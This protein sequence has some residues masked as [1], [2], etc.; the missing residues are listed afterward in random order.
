MSMTD[1]LFDWPRIKVNKNDLC[2]TSILNLNECH[3]RELE[4]A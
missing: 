4:F 2:A 1:G 3:V